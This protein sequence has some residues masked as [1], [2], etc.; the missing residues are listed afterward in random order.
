MAKKDPVLEELDKLNQRKKSIKTPGSEEDQW[1]KYLDKHFPKPVISG[2]AYEVVNKQV[3][4]G[5]QRF[6]IIDRNFKIIEEV[7]PVFNKSGNFTKEVEDLMKKYDLE[8][9]RISTR[10]S[11]DELKCTT[12][13]TF[14]I[15]CWELDF[16]KESSREYIE[17]DNWVTEQNEIS[18]N[19]FK[20]KHNI[21]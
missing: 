16:E 21:K 6:L 11:I 20:R 4:E 9:R 5:N 15:E 17:F 19:D 14:S 2:K 12:H 1:N 7:Q 18:F 10:D 13:T 3:V 8:S